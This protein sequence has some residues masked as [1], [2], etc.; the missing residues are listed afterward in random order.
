[1]NR[2]PARSTR[3]YTLLPH[4]TRFRSVVTLVLYD[5]AANVVVDPRGN[6]VALGVHRQRRYSES[7]C[8]V[9]RHD[10]GQIGVYEEGGAPGDAV[11]AVA[12]AV[13]DIGAGGQI[14][15]P[16]PPADIAHRRLIPDHGE[17]AVGVH[18]HRCW[19]IDR[20]SVV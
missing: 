17:I 9:Q 11:G 14:S 4:A 2:L 6:E 5:V 7:R 10:I 15:R 12:A 1:M 20:K 19:Q 18:R 8:A 16:E 3:T 13:D